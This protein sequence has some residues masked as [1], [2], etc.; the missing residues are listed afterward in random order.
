MSQVVDYAVNRL[1]SLLP[2]GA[3]QAALPR[4]LQALHR[5]FLRSLVERGRPLNEAEIS[6]LVPGGDAFT[7]LWTLVSMDLVVVD[8]RNR[9]VGAYPVTTERTPHAIHVNG[10]TIWAMCAFDAVSVEPMFGLPV[11]TASRC[12]ITGAEIHIEQRG[13]RIVQVSPSPDVQVGIW[14]RSPGS[15]AARNFCPGVMFLRDRTAALQW[16]AGQIADHDFAGVEEAAEAGA[17]FFKPLL[18]ETV[19]VVG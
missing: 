10:N 9:P 13:G 18:A 11:M 7:A 19:S 6:A 4:P 14:W 8:G 1:T 2:L 16:Q 15:V 3:R 5:A 12:P 17:R